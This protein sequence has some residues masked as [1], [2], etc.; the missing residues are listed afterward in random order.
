MTDFF[1]ESKK[2][3]SV[4][5]TNLGSCNAASRRGPGPSWLSNDFMMMPPRSNLDRN[6]TAKVPRLM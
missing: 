5:P 4:S 1:W 6:S 2:P 3:S